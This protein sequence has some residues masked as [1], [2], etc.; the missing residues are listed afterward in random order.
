MTCVGLNFDSGLTGSGMLLSERVCVLPKDPEL[1][2][3]EA[4]HT[5]NED[6]ELIACALG[7]AG[8]VVWLKQLNLMVAITAQGRPSDLQCARQV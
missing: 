2:L 4:V 1:A 3:V 7:C 6:Q 8:A 5:W